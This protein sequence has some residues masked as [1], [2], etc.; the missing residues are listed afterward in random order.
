MQKV[1]IKNFAKIE[2]SNLD[3]PRSEDFKWKKQVLDSHRDT[4]LLAQSVLNDS[5]S[6]R[7]RCEKSCDQAREVVNIWSDYEDR[8][9]KAIKNLSSRIEEFEK[10]EEEKKLKKELIEKKKC[11]IARS[12]A[13]SRIRVRGKFVPETRINS[14]R[15]L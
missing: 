13:L 2:I 7:D 9:S 3:S 12:T 5:R 15:V 8:F 6:S 11:K 1:Q 14:F 4:S 10:E